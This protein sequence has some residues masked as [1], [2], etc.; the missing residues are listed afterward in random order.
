MIKLV[1]FDNDGTI[2]DNRG[3]GDVGNILGLKKTYE[4]MGITDPLPSNDDM[5]RQMGKKHKD[6]FREIVK[7]PDFEKIYPVINKF[8]IEEVM[9]LIKQ[10]KGK[11]YPGVK[12]TIRK[13]RL[14]GIK[15]SVA[16]NGRQQ[17]INTISQTH[18]YDDLFDMV[19]GS[20]QINGDKGD[21]LIHQMKIL[22]VLP[23]ETLMVGDRISD[24]EAARKAGS[25]SAAALWGYGNEA[26]H[27]NATFKLN[28]IEDLLAI[29][30]TL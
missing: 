26:E 19:M 20:D 18:G 29:V 17:Y 16:T 30:T 12:E 24:I 13:L 6:M 5:I 2:Y 25:K 1:V 7:R 22:N 27:K 11:I 4:S 15:T 10:K 8:T 28:R 9:K 3:V 14:L 23:E 21:L